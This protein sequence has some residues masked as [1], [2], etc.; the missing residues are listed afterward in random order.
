MISQALLCFCTLPAATLPANSV[1]ALPFVEDL[2][3]LLFSFISCS[4]CFVVKSRF[5]EV[6]DGDSDDFAYEV[7]L[8]PP[9]KNSLLKFRLPTMSAA[10]NS[11]T[12]YSN[13]DLLEVLLH[14]LKSNIGLDCFVFDMLSQHFIRNLYMK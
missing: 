14:K 10:K 3:P 11:L 1:F 2:S 6:L 5:L 8:F 9:K 12:H 7:R 13:F 4:F